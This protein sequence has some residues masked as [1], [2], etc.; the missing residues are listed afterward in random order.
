MVERLVSLGKPLPSLCILNDIHFYICID[1][2]GLSLD[3]E[4]LRI[5]IYPNA[6]IDTIHSLCIRCA[7]VL[8][9][10]YSHT[11]AIFASLH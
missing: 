7:S 11:E 6:T 2:M 5:L 9:A 1:L 3:V 4:F 8:D 10:F